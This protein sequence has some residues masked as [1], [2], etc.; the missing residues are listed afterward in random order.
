MGL[1]RQNLSISICIL[2][3]LLSNSL[4]YHFNAKRLSPLHRPQLLSRIVSLPHLQLSLQLSEKP[5]NKLGPIRFI[6]KKVLLTVLVIKLN[7]L[8]V[9]SSL[10]RTVQSMVNGTENKQSNKYQ[11]AFAQLKQDKTYIKYMKNFWPRLFM[12]IFSFTM[13]RRY[14]AFTKSL[15]TEIPYTAFL[16]LISTTPERVLG[17]KVNP[18][19]FTFQ[20]DG[21]S[22]LT[23]I[24]NLEP[25]IM[26]RLLSS[27]VDFEAPATPTNVLGLVW[28]LA[29]GGFLFNLARKMMQGPQDEATGKRKDKAGELDAYGKLSFE[30]VAGQERAKLEVK[31][32]CDMLQAPERFTNVGARLPSGVL[33]VGPP[34]TGKTL[35]ARVAAAEAGVPFYACS[36]SDFVEVFVGRGPARVRKLF[37]DAAENAPCIVFVDEIDSI[38]RSRRMGSMNSEQENTLNQI[39]TCMDG[40]DTSNN[41]VI[42]M[43]A[44]N[45]FELLDPALLRSGR[46]DRIVQ[47]PLPDIS[48]RSAILKVHTK[49]LSL[50]SDVDLE[51]VSK[52]TGGTCGADL[53]AICNEAAIRTVRR[54]GLE[55]CQE[56]F[57][58]ALKSFFSARGVPL[59]GMAEA[60]GINLPSWL[61]GF[62]ITGGLAEALSG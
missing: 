34:G 17:L 35:L 31:E 32:V 27:G 58:D 29:Y 53:S 38:G 48:G 24:V 28:T 45:R 15:T 57:E 50:A 56:D 16:K 25:T 21:K 54:G 22:A 1:F 19:L 44:T 11:K 5:P 30:D 3:V 20:L 47:C 43:G 12:L 37:K 23:R 61:K 2:L 26:G 42:V 33:L 60:A 4:A 59:A 7:S 18:S 36:A 14:L 46:F 10:L 55:I 40:L 41:G 6:Q 51:R 39:L 9:F 49:K 62:G 8:K 52:L 13:L